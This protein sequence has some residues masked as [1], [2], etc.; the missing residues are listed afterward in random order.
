MGSNKYRQVAKKMKMKLAFAMV[1]YVTNQL[2][3]QANRLLHLAP[4]DDAYLLSCSLCGFNTLWYHGIT[5]M[6][7]PFFSSS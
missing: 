4:T 3:S 2:D 7:W 1:L 6:F 5:H